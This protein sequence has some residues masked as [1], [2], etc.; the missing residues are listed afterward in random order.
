MPSNAD[1]MRKVNLEVWIQYG[2]YCVE[3]SEKLLNSSFPVVEANIFSFFPVGEKY[4]QLAV[5][6]FTQ[7]CSIG[8]ILVNQTTEALEAIFNSEK[9]DVDILW[10]RKDVR[11]FIHG[12]FLLSQASTVE[13]GSG[14]YEITGTLAPR[15]SGIL[16]GPIIDESR[17]NWSYDPVGRDLDS[18]P[19]AISLDLANTEFVMLIQDN[20][21]TAGAGVDIGSAHEIDIL[22]DPDNPGRTE[23]GSGIIRL[24]EHRLDLIR[25]QGRRQ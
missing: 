16:Y 20:D 23:I 25:V 3:L 18:G 13:N 5:T 6:D 8:S 11:R 1:F 10:R 24:T 19:A 4:E 21:G 14:L 22:F 12:E 2:D 7:T 17:P 15:G 9:K